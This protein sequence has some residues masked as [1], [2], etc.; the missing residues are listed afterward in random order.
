MDKITNTRCVVTGLGMISAIGNNVDEC[1]ANALAGKTGIDK[2]ASVD[3]TDCY[4]NLG[5]EVHCDTLDEI[6]EAKDVD[7]VSKLCLKA[8]KEALDDAG[9]VIDESNAGRVGVVMGSCVGGVVSVENY[10][11]KGEHAED[12][13]M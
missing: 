4:A 8:S 2:V 5:A 1:F 13:N 12:I 10:V 9:L 11:T 6:D 7:R 3:T